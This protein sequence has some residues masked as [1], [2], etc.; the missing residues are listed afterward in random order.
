MSGG[1]YSIA[2]NLCYTMSDDGKDG[3]DLKDGLKFGDGE[4]GG[5]VVENIQENLK[6]EKIK[7]NGDSEI[8]FNHFLHKEGGFY[9]DTK[10]DR[11]HN[12][13]LVHL[14]EN[15]RKLTQ[16]FLKKNKA[17]VLFVEKLDVDMILELQRRL[18]DED[19]R[20]W[21]HLLSEWYYRFRKRIADQ[22]ADVVFSVFKERKIVNF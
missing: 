7:N 14:N 21:R 2:V 1:G 19:I 16:H 10:S 4:I 6:E 5:K 17:P 8:P 18:T 15:N 13:K 11:I 9:Y 3:G 22:F 20:L 12:L